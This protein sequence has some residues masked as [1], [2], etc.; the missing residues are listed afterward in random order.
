MLQHYFISKQLS[1]L[2]VP[3]RRL[4]SSNVCCI[5]SVRTAI[6]RQDE[7]AIQQ[8]FVLLPTRFHKINYSNNNN[9]KSIIPVYS[10]RSISTTTTISRKNNLLFISQRSYYSQ[11]H[12][13]YFQISSLTNNLSKSYII[14]NNNIT[15]QQSLSTTASM[16][17]IQQ[18]NNPVQTSI[19]N[20]LTTIFQPSYLEVINESHRHN[21]YVN[22]KCRFV[23]LFACL[24]ALITIFVIFVFVELIRN[25]KRSFSNRFFSLFCFSSVII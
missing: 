7:T 8:Q 11:L 13:N 15:K 5:G 16:V 21:V 1:N 6:E 10:R 12:N 3:F 23:F 18:Q 22:T 25:K 19:E 20:Q 2:L 9:I 17:A 24:L 4:L 14:D